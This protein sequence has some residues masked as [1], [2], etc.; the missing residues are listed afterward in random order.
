MKWAD[1][2]PTGASFHDQRIRAGNELDADV[3]QLR[4]F[5][6]KRK[7]LSVR[8]I[9]ERYP[10]HLSEQLSITLSNYKSST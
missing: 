5:I 3:T 10:I 9:P 1:L 2:I 4:V 7:A 8:D 6:A